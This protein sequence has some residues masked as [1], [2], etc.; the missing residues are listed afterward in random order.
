M[1]QH[2]SWMLIYPLFEWSR[3]VWGG[4]PELLSG[5]LP[6]INHPQSALAFDTRADGFSSAGLRSG[7]RKSAESHTSMLEL[8]VLAASR[9]TG[10]AAHESNQLQHDQT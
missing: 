3:G 2:A 7:G 4:K 5:L 1:T 6:E 8:H 9:R 10:R